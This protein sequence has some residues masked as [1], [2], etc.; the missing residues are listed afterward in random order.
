MPLY[1]LPDKLRQKVRNRDD[2]IACILL[3][4]HFSGSVLGLIPF[5]S[6]NVIFLTIL[7]YL[8]TC[9]QDKCDISYAPKEEKSND[10]HGIQYEE[11]SDVLSCTQ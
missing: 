1:A 2:A 6:H 5:L 10:Q 8:L 11:V 3:Q 7:F 4:Q 9:Y